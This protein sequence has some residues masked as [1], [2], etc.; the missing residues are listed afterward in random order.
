KYREAIDSYLQAL[1]LEQAQGGINNPEYA[2]AASGLSAC[3]RPLKDL[4][5]SAKY[6]EIAAAAFCQQKNHKQAIDRL[7]DLKET[8]SVL[9]DAVQVKRIDALIRSVQPKLEEKR[10]STK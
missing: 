2:S 7:Y 4:R 8:Y 6:G 5:L 3:Y 9:H 10:I 1:P